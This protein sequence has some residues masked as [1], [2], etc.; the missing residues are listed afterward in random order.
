LRILFGLK[1]VFINSD[2]LF[3][4]PRV[5]TKDIIGD[6]V[7]PCREARFPPETANMLIGTKKGFLG[8]VI[9]QGQVCPGKL[10]KQTSDTRLMPPDQFAKSMLVFMDKNASDEVR[11]S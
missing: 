8:K 7:K 9:G 3:A 6:P 2:E 10:A 4:P 5:L 1:L 11:I